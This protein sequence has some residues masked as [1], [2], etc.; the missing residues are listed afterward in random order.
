[1]TNKEYT[2]RRD[3]IYEASFSKGSLYGRWEITKAPDY[4]KFIAEAIDQ[5]VLDVIGEET[6]TDPLMLGEIKLLK[7]CE[8]VR[9]MQRAIVNESN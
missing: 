1:M 3:E 4:K 6:I 7:H 5:L 8:Q 2:K 9:Q